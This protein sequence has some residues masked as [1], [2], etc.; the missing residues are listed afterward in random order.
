MTTSI[1]KRQNQNM[2]LAVFRKETLRTARTVSMSCR[3]FMPSLLIFEMP[4]IKAP[5]RQMAPAS[6]TV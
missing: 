2:A 4:M 3:R 1:I 6:F 5:P